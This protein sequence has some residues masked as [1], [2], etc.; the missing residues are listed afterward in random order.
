MKNKLSFTSKFLIKIS[1][2]LFGF[3][4]IFQGCHLQKIN[5]GKK[6]EDINEK[7]EMSEFTSID[8]LIISIDKF[9]KKRKRKSIKI[10]I[11]VSDIFSTGTSYYSNESKEVFEQAASKLLNYS[12]QIE[13]N[14]YS[15][16]TGRKESVLKLTKFRAAAIADLF[17][18][19]GF[20]SNQI[21]INGY[22]SQYPIGSNETSQGRKLNRRIE[23]IINKG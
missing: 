18:K 21:T 23:I 12:C 11:P 16:N 8:S 22:G 17:L 20:E 14:C 9:L 7:S 4:I 2:S 5:K 15:D 10:I 3:L 6:Y 1:F 19:N 13:L